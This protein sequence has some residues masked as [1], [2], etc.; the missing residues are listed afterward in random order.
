MKM[1]KIIINIYKMK[2]KKI[3]NIYKNKYIFKLLNKFIKQTKQ[4]II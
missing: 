2:M 4:T 1:K 3:I